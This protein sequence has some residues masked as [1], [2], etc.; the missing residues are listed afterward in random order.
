[1]QARNAYMSHDDAANYTTCPRKR[2]RRAE[3]ISRRNQVADIQFMDKLLVYPLNTVYS[4]FH[5]TLVNF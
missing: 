2:W 5:D 4:S 3:H 1:M